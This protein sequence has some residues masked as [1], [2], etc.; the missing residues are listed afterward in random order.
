MSSGGNYTQNE[1]ETEQGA[2]DYNNN[3]TVNADGSCADQLIIFPGS[4]MRC[5]T[6]GTQTLYFQCCQSMSAA[7]IEAS[8]AYD[9]NV[10]SPDEKQLWVQRNDD[11]CVQIG[12]YCTEKWLGKYCVQKKITH[13]CFSDEFQKAFVIA[14]KDL[15]GE[16]WGTPESPSCGGFSPEQLQELGALGISDHPAMQA[17]AEKMGAEM[18]EKMTEEMTTTLDPAKIQGEVVNDL[19]GLK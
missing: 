12:E 10:C 11:A 5:R 4:D 2:N 6:P 15:L 9:Q 17:Y 8:E 13:C 18:A 3:G 1:E 7:D 19:E 14:G 16:G